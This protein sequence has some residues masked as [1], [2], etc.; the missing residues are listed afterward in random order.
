MRRLPLLLA[1]CGLP[2]LAF[3]PAC[4]SSGGDDGNNSDGG[5]GSDGSHP[6]SDGSGS[7][8]TLTTI[9]QVQNDANLVGSDVTLTGVVVTAIDAYGNNT[10][11]FWVQDPSPA[12]TT[13]AGV[14]VYHG[15]LSVV[16]TLAPGDIVNISG[17]IKAEFA[18][19]SDTSGQ[20]ET[21][22]EPASGGTMTIT[23]TGS[24][25]VPA[26]V[27]V[28]ALAIGQMTDM[29]ARYAAWEPTEGMLI[30]LDNVADTGHFGMSTSDPTSQYFEVTG[31][32][33]PQSNLA[34]FPADI[35]TGTCFSS[36]TGVQSYFGFNT[37]L[38]PRTTADMV[39]GGTSCPV[40]NTVA[41]CED[42]IDNDGNGFADCADFS[43]QAV[44]PS[45]ASSA[46]VVGVQMGT[47]TGVVTL[48]NVYVTA[49]GSKAIWVADSLTA[50]QYD[51][52]E[53]YFGVAPASNLV[54]GAT[55]NVTGTAF[56]LANTAMT[57]ETMTEIKNPSA[58][59]V[60]AATTAPTPATTASV[61]TLAALGATGE[62]WE[63]VLVKVTNVKI[64]AVVSTMFNQLT[65]TDNTG[66]TIT[67]D[68]DSFFGYGSTTNPVTLPIVG[69]CYASL[70]GVMDVQT[71]DQIRTLNPRNAA[72]MVTTGGSCN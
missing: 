37:I 52:V 62:P 30:T 54:I 27:V 71:T 53:V 6:G 41:L 64:T 38:Y 22:I 66:S 5:H 46:T 55:V 48:S 25:N 11:D 13:Y 24:G 42:G 58:T 68:D 40:E 45:C 14:H 3:S 28:N 20:T 4:R 43:C 72:D 17:A 32:I 2:L 15:D 29:T 10:G 57:G 36:I 63:G 16:A 1:L 12:A 21:E 61:A 7:G 49:V 47:D 33:E 67:M 44:D 23:K 60:A 19:T 70:T 50:A 56:E 69:T 65:L 51:G 31:D 34:A 35:A 8:G 18:L 9:E 26:P 39:T 59:F